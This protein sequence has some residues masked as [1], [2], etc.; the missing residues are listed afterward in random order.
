MNKYVANGFSF[1]MLNEPFGSLKFCQLS[2]RDF[3]SQ[4]EDAKS[5]IGH[6]DLARILK[7]PY[8]RESIRLEKGDVLYIAQLI[9]GRLKE[10]A[11]ELPK[12]CRL[13]FMEISYK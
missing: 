8:N 3:M 7:L 1:Q 4:T 10:G 5:V 2:Q 12:D 11:T 13:K 9:G 6:E